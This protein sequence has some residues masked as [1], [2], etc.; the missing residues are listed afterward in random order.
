MAMFPLYTDIS[1][2]GAIVNALI[3][4][5]V[6]LLRAQDDGMDGIADETVLDR[7]AELRR[8]LFTQ[9]KDFAI[10]AEQ[11]ERSSVPFYCVIY[12]AQGKMPIPACVSA[13]ELVLGATTANEI[14]NRL[15]RLP[16]K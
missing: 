12:M 2:N 11:R 14:E 3:R 7:A 6:D 9:D 5:G 1:V 8:V 13:I 15:Y 4:A 16:H 10:I